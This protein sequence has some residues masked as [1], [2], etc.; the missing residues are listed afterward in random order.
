MNRYS[1]AAA[2]K[3]L[4]AGVTVAAI[5]L[6]QAMAYALIAGVDPKFGIYSAI[7]VTLVASIFGSSSHLINGPTN[8]ISLVVFS[9]LA[10]FDPEARFDVFQGMFLL[11]IMVGSIQI[12]IA[13]FKLGDLTRYISE[14]VVLGF[15]AGAGSLVALGQVANFF[16][17]HDKGTG[18]QHV[19]L[20]FWLTITQ[21]GAVSP[22]AL[23]IGFGTVVLVLLLRKLTRKYR[24]PQVD[25]LGALIVAASVAAALGW[26]QPG[27]NGKA[28]LSIVGNVPAS[29]PRPHIPE[30]QFGWIGELSGSALAISCLGLLEALA[31]SKAIAHETRQSLDFNRQ[32]LAEGLANLTGGFFQCLPGSGSLTRSAINYQAGAV[33]RMSGIFAA[34]SV[35]IVLLVFAPLMRYVPKAALAGLLMVIASRLIDWKRL[36][37]ALGASRYDAGLV[38]LTAFASVFVSVEFSILIGVGVSILLFLPRAAKLRGAEL[39][40]SDE[41]VVRDR[42]PSD[43]ACTSMII[44]DFDGDLFFGAAPELDGYFADLQKRAL[45]EG[46]RCIVLRV[47]TTN[48]PDMVCMERF[49]HF[50]LDMDRHGVF[51]LLCGVRP[52]FARV[53]KNMRFAEILPESRV[54]LEEPELYSS[55][56]KAVRRGYELLGDQSCEHCARIQALRPHAPD[57]ARDLYYLV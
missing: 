43:P 5:S 18:H 1:S 26:S 10:F 25:M 15:M 47:K 55:T 30:I 7:V 51:V 44:F 57:E 9:A 19:L 39:I 54:F 27:A 35:A 31:I 16:G 4:L 13:V 53:M 24:L 41:G 28:V 21:G 49:H 46:I 52:E 14:S 23:G 34:G 17:L 29:L 38:L 50:I 8:A 56:L 40:V 32:C 3:D 12:L 48:S 2:R 37:S 42:L 33:S 45:A 11:G 20:R 22:H 36:R 6:P